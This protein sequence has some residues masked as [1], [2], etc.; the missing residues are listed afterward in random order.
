MLLVNLASNIFFLLLLGAYIVHKVYH[1]RAVFL[2][3]NAVSQQA[4]LL[5]NKYFAFT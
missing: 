5:F 2:N 1:Y 4:A 3:A